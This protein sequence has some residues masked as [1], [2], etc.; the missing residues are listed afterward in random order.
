VAVNISAVQ[1]R[2]KDFV[3]GIRAAPQETGL[4]PRYIEFELTETAPMQDPASTIAVLHALKDIGVR[5]TL[6]DFGTGHSSLSYLKRFP[7]DVLKIDKSFVSGL[8]TNTCDAN[9]V[10]AIINMGR[11][12]RLRVIAERVETRKQ[13]LRLQAQQSAEGRVTIPRAG[14]CQRIR[15]DAETRLV[16]DDRRRSAGA[17]IG[18]SQPLTKVAYHL[19]GSEHTMPCRRPQLHGVL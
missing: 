4:D 13:F 6:D 14:G 17:T 2:T 16:D 19:C 12:F 18:D 8:C 10:S 1:L 11:S 3:Q 5:L 9:I 15:Q 7:I